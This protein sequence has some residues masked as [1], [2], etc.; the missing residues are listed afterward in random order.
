MAAYASVAALYIHVYF[1]YHACSFSDSLTSGDRV[2]SNNQDGSGMN[3]LGLQLMLLRDEVRGECRS[4]V[5]E[6]PWT[7]WLKQLGAG[8]FETFLDSICSQ[9]EMSLVFVLEVGSKRMDSL[10]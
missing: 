10:G 8:T 7:M 3:W 1:L 5:Y 2:W 4:R 9:P 6:G